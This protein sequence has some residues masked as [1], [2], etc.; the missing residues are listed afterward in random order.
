MG[1]RCHITGLNILA[2]RR[3]VTDPAHKG[4]IELYSPEDC[5]NPVITCTHNMI[6]LVG[7]MRVFVYVEFGRRCK[8]G[9]GLLWMYCGNNEETA[10]WMKDIL[11]E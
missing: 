9:P 6:R 5:H 2:L 10:A 3:T 8:G 1:S 7:K 4:E 11:F